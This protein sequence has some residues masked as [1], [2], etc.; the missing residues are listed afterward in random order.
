MSSL[1]KI[2]IIDCYDSFTFNLAH[3]IEPLVNEVHIIRVD[4][5]KIDLITKYDA[6]ILSPGPGLPADYKILKQVI[7]KSNKP[8][9]GVCL[10]LQAIVEA[11]GGSLMNLPCVW[12]GIARETYVD[13]SDE[14][15]K[16]IPHKIYTARYH[17]W[18]A[19]QVPNCLKIIAYDLDGYIMAISHNHLP[20][21]AV[22]F[23]PESIL[24]DYGYQMVKNWIKT[25]NC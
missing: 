21:K 20:I 8:I 11:F 18:A 14:L 15:F 6:I 22:Q 23:H 1:I 7:L 13:N 24:T 25:L 19:K 10:G 4:K 5:F 9:F 12:H 16:N 3:Y 17:S 2:L